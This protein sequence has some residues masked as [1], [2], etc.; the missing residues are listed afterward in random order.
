[1]K[2]FRH[3]MEKLSGY[4]SPESSDPFADREQEGSSP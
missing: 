1:L 3:Q 4:W 2:Q